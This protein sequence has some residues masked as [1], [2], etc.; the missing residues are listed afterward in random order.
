MNIYQ[1]NSEVNNNEIVDN[2]YQGVF[3]SSDAY[4]G[5]PQAV[6]R[7][8]YLRGSR[9]DILLCAINPSSKW[10]VTTAELS[11]LSG[12]HV[13]TV[14]AAMIDLMAIGHAERIKSS[15]GKHD[16]HYKIHLYP[17][18]HLID[19]YAAQG[20]TPKSKKFVDVKKARQVASFDAKDFTF[21]YGG[22]K[23]KSLIEDKGVRPQ[24]GQKEAKTPSQDG[25]IH[26][27]FSALE[28]SLL[29][30]KRE[31]EKESSSYKVLVDGSGQACFPRERIAYDHGS[32]AAAAFLSALPIRRVDS[33][34]G[35][36]ESGAEAPLARY[37]E[38]HIEEVHDMI[39]TTLQSHKEE[40]IDSQ[41]GCM[42]RDNL[43]DLAI[44]ED[45]M[46]SDPETDDAPKAAYSEPQSDKIDDP[47]I[48]EDPFKKRSQGSLK[49]SEE[50][51]ASRPFQ[52][53]HTPSKKVEK[54][55]EAAPQKLDHPK[56]KDVLP[57]AHNEL[58]CEWRIE[59]SEFA[60]IWEESN[61]DV[62]II[63]TV[64][65]N[66][67][68]KI[69]GGANIGKKVGYIIAGIRGKYK[70]KGLL[71]GEIAEVESAREESDA[72]SRRE[73]YEWYDAKKEELSR[74]GLVCSLDERGISIAEPCGRATDA[75]YCDSWR[76]VVEAC[77]DRYAE[78][79]R[80]YERI[81]MASR[82]RPMD[83]TSRQIGEKKRED[84]IQRAARTR[85]N[86]DR[87]EQ[88]LKAEMAARAGSIRDEWRP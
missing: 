76:S 7:N 84:A 65:R 63:K 25:F 6:N 8:K 49:K 22:M 70:S 43:K 73:A 59:D 62:E 74:Y 34:A 18:K 67:Y 72:V 57:Y 3:G 24:F 75:R 11:H 68:E 40:G 58:I 42:L 52:Q 87:A 39:D 88:M 80:Q 44:Q 29:Q 51:V 32:L 37:G 27:G 60:K 21:T 81:R 33:P 56:P 78:T 82:N 38:D 4:V 30:K 14:R 77:V 85:D 17:Q 28:T 36:R 2:G 10:R 20:I 16:C 35:S 50:R 46:P 86:S 15:G 13:T 9:K 53:T 47:S 45:D 69:K 23:N 26:D 31:R 48:D 1:N 71:P 79:H 61:G 19:Q 55:L 83:V 12:L 5:L 41:E 54:R 64:I 66:L